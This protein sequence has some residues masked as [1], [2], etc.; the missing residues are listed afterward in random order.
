[1]KKNNLFVS[2]M[3][4]IPALV[5][6]VATII[7]FFDSSKSIIGLILLIFSSVILTGGAVLSY[8]EYNKLSALAD[9]SGSLVGL[10]GYRLSS[11]V[12]G[13]SY[14]FLLIW[15][16]CLMIS[17]AFAIKNYVGINKTEEESI[18]KRLNITSLVLTVITIVFMICLM[19]F[20]IKAK[21]IL[22]PVILIIIVGVIIASKILSIVMNLKSGLWFMVLVPILTIMG[23]IPSE[24]GL[25]ENGILLSFIIYILTIVLAITEIDSLKGNK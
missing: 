23:M 13:N 20:L 9:L 12:E 11:E 24:I 19:A 15:F 21:A 6:L 4:G 1:M 14:H 3:A 17:L 7:A 10:I 22:T 16:M 5:I 25:Y 2:I 18:L 8:F